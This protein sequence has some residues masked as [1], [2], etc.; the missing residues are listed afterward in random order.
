[1]GR[2]FT[3]KGKH[4]LLHKVL[5][6]GLIL[7]VCTT[8]A[9]VVTSAQYTSRFLPGT[10]ISGIDCSEQTLEE[11]ESAIRSREEQ[12]KLTIRFRGGS[13]EVLTARDMDLKYDCGN[14]LQKIMSG[15]NTYS[16]L[17]R[18]FGNES[19][20]SLKTGYSYG[21]TTLAGTIAKLPELREGNYTAPADAELCLERGLTFGVVP[22]QEGTQIKADVLAEKA[23][24]A[25][26][27]GKAVLDLTSM[28]EVYE[29][30]SVRSDD[31]DLNARME[32]LN[33]LLEAN[34]Q[35]KMSDGSFREVNK[36][37]TINWLSLD[38]NGLATVDEDVVR[39]K[40]AELI[41]DVAREDDNYGY[42]RPF[43]STNY[44]MQRFDSDNLHGHT[45]DQ[46]RMSKTLATMVLNGR[47]GVIN[48]QYSEYVDALDPH[49]GGTYAEVD[50]YEQHVYYYQ[51]NQLVFDCSCVTGTEGYSSTPSGIFSIDEKIRGRELNGYRPDGT[52]SYS[53]YVKYW[54]CFLPHYGFHDA[55][56]RDSFGGNI[57]EYDGSHGCINLPTSAA[58]TLYDLIDYGTPVVVFRGQI[59]N[60]KP[61]EQTTAEDEVG[62]EEY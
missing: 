25:I 57:Y 14:E 33:K 36:R 35:I 5:P 45:L 19:S 17:S 50:I 20:H 32:A 26:K 4:L 22:E 13:E 3:K 61:L 51:D 1:M 38:E 48:P 58:A 60:D 54:M 21:T 47:S 46:A 37:T 29:K 31:E 27:A 40:A 43:A 23:G 8:G 62:S 56:W 34:V 41:A 39:E 12:Y 11:A 6:A 44:G 9:Y 52:L 16:W 10:T 18:E 49:L 55:S 59:Y 53:V 15:Q 42:F 24:E 2:K 30:P 7:A 28:D